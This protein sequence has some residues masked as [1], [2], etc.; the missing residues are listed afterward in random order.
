MRDRPLTDPLTDANL[1]FLLIKDGKKQ[2]SVQSVT[3][4]TPLTEKTFS[5]MTEESGEGQRKRCPL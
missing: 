2:G 1:L 5:R 4:I 3:K